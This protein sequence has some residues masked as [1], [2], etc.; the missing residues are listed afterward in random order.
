MTKLLCIVVY[1][2]VIAP[3]LVLVHE[4]GHVAVALALVPQDVIVRI[5]ARP[6]VQLL[7]WGRLQVLV[8]LW[9]GWVGGWGWA[10]D[11]VEVDK[12]HYIC[13]VLAG[14]AASL[15]TTFLCAA[16]K[17][18]LQDG[19]RIAYVLA[20]TARVGA[21]ATFAYTMIPMKYPSWM[22]GQPGATSDGYRIWYYLVRKDSRS[23]LFRRA[24][25]DE[26]LDGG[27]RRGR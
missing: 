13:M 5:G 7:K 18:A 9:G 16:L 24:R 22:Y 25:H 4:L 8:Q 11:E 27:E 14:P 2:A 3:Q 12:V 21:I 1:L 19:P 17:N 6:T 15:L 23:I 20:D 26:A 10:A